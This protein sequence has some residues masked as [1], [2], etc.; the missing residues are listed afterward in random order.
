M[1]RARFEEIRKKYR[2]AKR[3]ESNSDLLSLKVEIESFIKNLRATDEKNEDLLAEAQDILV[4]LIKII[5]ES[6]CH[7]FRPKKINVAL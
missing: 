7:P 4:D 2:D 6:H 5:D 1:N 3:K